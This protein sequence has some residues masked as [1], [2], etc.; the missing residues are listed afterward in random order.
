MERPLV[1]VTQPQIT[2][3]AASSSA[4]SVPADTSARDP[5]AALVASLEAC[6]PLELPDSRYKDSEPSHYDEAL[7]K[8]SCVKPNAVAGNG[9]K[10]PEKKRRVADKDKAQYGNGRQMRPAREMNLNSKRR[11]NELLKLPAMRIEAGDLHASRAYC[12]IPTQNLR[13]M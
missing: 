1:R 8:M 9:R 4:Y 12:V 3:E 13:V 10:Q 6:A 11:L 2:S 5:L 7:M